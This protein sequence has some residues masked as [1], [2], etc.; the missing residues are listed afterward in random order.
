[1]RTWWPAPLGLLAFVVRYESD[2]G[3]VFPAP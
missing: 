1:L 2:V 3:A